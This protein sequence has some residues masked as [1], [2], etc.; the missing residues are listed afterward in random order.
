MRSVAYPLLVAVVVAVALFSATGCTRDRD[1]GLSGAVNVF[2][3]NR[4]D[5]ALPLLQAAVEKS[6]RDPAGH[7][8]LA[9][10]LRRLGRYDEA[11]DQAYDAIAIDPDNAFA[12]SVLADLF[13]SQYSTW[14]RVDADSTWYHLREAVQSDPND[15][16]AWSHVWL[17][18]MRRGQQN[19]E[20]RAAIRMIDSGWLAKPMIEYNRWQLRYLPLGAILLTNGDMDTYP[21]IALQ[22]KEGLREDVAV[23]N[24]SLLNMA[25]YARTM[26]ERY[27]IPLP[28]APDELESL[29][30]V[31]DADGRVVT[32]SAQIVRAWAGM[33]ASGALTR[34]LCAAVTVD[35]LSLVADAEGRQVLCGPYIEIAAE[36]VSVDSDTSRLRVCL[37]EIV[38]SDFKGQ[39][40]SD[41]D[42]SPVRRSGSNRIGT[43]I[44]SAML[45]YI[46]AMIDAGR[47]SEAE[48]MLG[49]AED[50]N[51]HMLATDDLTSHLEKR[52]ETLSSR[53]QG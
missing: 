29:Q 20:V 33:L 10:C 17:E 37:D 14:D 2:L 9:E 8:W 25:W 45:R 26:A 35:D 11:A 6:P 39:F 12:H 30:P 31:R 13:A 36:P 24:L 16:N 22:H 46:D 42:R 4:L 50:L 44:T 28:V 51:S 41:L 1:G 53:K 49:R 43:N 3:E 19:L 48:R 27:D 52:R 23:V 32:P 5:E 18:A 47:W 7:A 38:P 40:T 34:P 21:S 15:G